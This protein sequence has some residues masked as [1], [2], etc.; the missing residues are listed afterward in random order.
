MWRKI[1]EP[2]AQSLP[3]FSTRS[4]ISTSVISTTPQTVPSAPPLSTR[5]VACIGHGIR[6]AGE[7]TGTEDLFVDGEVQGSIRIPEGMVTVG[8][9]GRVEG[10]IEAREVAV[11]GEVEGDL[12]A[13]ERVHI[14]RTGQ[15]MG[16]IL[17]KRVL[18]E[19]GADI[20]GRVE[21][22]R[23]RLEGRTQREEPAPGE[24]N[25]AVALSRMVG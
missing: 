16:E 13:T 12:H 19:D 21:T 25:E 10:P 20:R 23:E 14:W 7:I 2:K 5:P 1:E 15:T 17:A 9:N 24:A 6:I 18:I 11:R 4:Q 3:D 22:L 8:P